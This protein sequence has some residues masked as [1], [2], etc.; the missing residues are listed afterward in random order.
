[1]GSL[2]ESEDINHLYIT[3]ERC[4]NH[5]FHDSWCS[6]SGV[7]CLLC[8]ACCAEAE[9]AIN[10]EWHIQEYGWEGPDSTV[11]TKEDAIEAIMLMT[12]D[13]NEAR[14]K[15]LEEYMSR[16]APEATE[17]ERKQAKRQKKIEAAKRVSKAQKQKK[18]QE[19]EEEEE[20]EEEGERKG[21]FK[22]NLQAHKCMH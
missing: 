9:F 7:P 15:A 11:P 8:C 5:S 2:C 22:G 10:P 18:A 21:E 6:L 3:Y 12:D 14:R 20:E 17:A 4:M 1:M 19:E 13:Q 16:E